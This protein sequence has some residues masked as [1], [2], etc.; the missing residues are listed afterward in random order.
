MANAVTTP[1]NRSSSRRSVARAAGEIHITSTSTLYL[2]GKPEDDKELVVYANAD[3]SNNKTEE[4]EK[5]TI[6]SLLLTSWSKVDV[7]METQ[8]LVTYLNG[9]E[10]NIVHI[11]LGQLRANNIINECF[12]F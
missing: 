5:T 3:V 10:E 2:N 6:E 8:T 12:S 7:S 11:V 4:T 9:M 1:P